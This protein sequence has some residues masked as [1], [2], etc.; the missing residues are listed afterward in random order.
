[1]KWIGQHIWSF[2]SRFRSD[3]YLE[4]VADHGSDP[5]RFLTIDS[6]T[7]KVTYRTGTEVL[8]DIGGASS[9]SDVTGITITA[10]DAGTATDTS[11]N[12]DITITGGA[13][14][15]TEATGSTLTI[16]VDTA[17][18]T[19]RG[20]VELAT[21]AETTT[22]TDTYRAVT[23]DSLKDGYQGSA[24]VTTLGTIG[25][26]TWQGTA[27]ASTYLDA[28]TSHLSVAQTMTGRK[29]INIR[30][31][32]VTSSTDGAFM[33]DVI[34]V[35]SGST[36]LGKIYY[37]RTDGSWALT[38]ADSS[39]STGF[40]A[41]ALGTDPDSDGMLIRG[42]VTLSQEIAGTEAVGNPLYIDGVTTGAATITVPSGTGDFVRVIGYVMDTDDQIYFNPD[43]TWVEIA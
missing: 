19:S 1:M 38:D 11:G 29:T 24:N 7:G 16:N 27:I 41:V 32:D 8:S 13:S 35:G 39:A 9:S 6:S 42:M 18:V 31:F 5:D 10:D 3:V 20:I 23:P 25:T 17:S 26:G 4:S 14:V 30:R 15:D 40:L 37:L 12:L 36:V 28:D 22:G 21:T 34:F 43:N 2:I 33:G